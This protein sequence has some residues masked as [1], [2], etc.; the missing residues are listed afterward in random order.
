MSGRNILFYDQVTV[1]YRGRTEPAAY[2]LT[3]P[4]PE[5]A[6]TAIVGES[7]SGKST[8]L[9]LAM[10]LLPTGGEQAEGRVLFNGEEISTFSKKRLREIRGGEM[11][12][13][14][15]DPGACF[16]PRRKLGMQFVESYK[17]HRAGG[18]REALAA[19]GEILSG[20]G[21]S[22]PGDLFRRYSFELS[23]GQLQ[24]AALGMAMMMK[25]KLLLCDEPTS[26]LD[27]VVQ[28]EVAGYLKDL[29]QKA[30]TALLLVTHNLGLAAALGDYI[31]V[32]E[33]GHLIEYGPT[34]QII[35]SPREGYTKRLIKSVWEV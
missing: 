24:R 6:V 33:K 1:R 23:G 4:V 21:F 29:H 34:E 26:A 20:L 14:F 16:D 35:H 13:V 5:K 9:R 27:P 31:A 30:G 15:Q 28:A 12:M 18:K 8:L 11:A 7:G 10:G 32:M 19:A 17:A 2:K 3:L 25:P 22:D